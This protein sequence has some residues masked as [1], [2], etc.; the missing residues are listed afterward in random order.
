ML[1]L[2][3]VEGLMVAHILEMSVNALLWQLFTIYQGGI[4]ER[5]SVMKDWEILVNI[6]LKK[7]LDF[8][9]LCIDT[10]EVANI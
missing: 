6:Q 8:K 10:F 7:V 9:C 2:R 1:I 3:N 5:N 4:T